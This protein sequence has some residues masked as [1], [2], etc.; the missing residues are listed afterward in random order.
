MRHLS[1]LIKPASGLC[2]LR[3]VYCFYHAHSQEDSISIPQKI[4]PDSVAESLVQK[5]FDC[6]QNSISF[7]FQGGEP[8]LAGLAFFENFILLIKKYRPPH[9]GVHFSI[10]TNGTLLNEQWCDFFR[11]Y[12]FLVGLS[13]DG[14]Q[15]IHDALRK[16]NKGQ[17][18]YEQVVAAYKM[19]VA[20]QVDVNILCVVTQKTTG[21]AKRVYSELGNMGCRH[22]QFIPCLDQSSSERGNN[23]YSLL[24][25]QYGSFLKEIFDMWYTDWKNDTYRSIRLFDDYVRIMANM[26]PSSCATAGACGKYAVIEAD[27]SV[28]PC[29]FYVR[30][31]YL[32]GN[33]TE[34]SFEEV[35]N[36]PQATAFMQESANRPPTC[37]SCKYSA[38]CMGGC[39]RDWFVQNNTNHNYYCQSFKNFF[40]HA[41]PRLSIVAQAERQAQAYARQ[42][43]NQTTLQK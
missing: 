5:A 7:A 40:E 24:P 36:S 35:L 28:Y 19:L 43:F 23:S 16:D 15:K 26:A 17:T 21:L 13:I 32:L 41:L 31:Q 22:M 9:V 14:L 10:Q 2:N 12:N 27:G 33:I 18:T 34:N 37:A 6:A 1:V 42:K 39:K 29:D 20:K 8:T 38:I 4:M 25:A 30:N 3:C 11:K